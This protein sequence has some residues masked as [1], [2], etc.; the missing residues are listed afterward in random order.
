LKAGDLH[1]Q[2]GLSRLGALLEDAEDDGRSVQDFDA[3]RELEVSLLAWAQLSIDEDHLG[4][5]V[6]A[7]GQGGK[8]LKF[9]F[10]HEGRRR[11]RGSL[12]DGGVHHPDAEAAREL[13]ELRE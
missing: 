13:F 11:P 4:D 9:P 3:E 12:L 1:F 6:G 2:A 7:P 8:L 5:D 10:T